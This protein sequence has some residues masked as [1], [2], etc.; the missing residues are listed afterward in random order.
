MFTLEVDASTQALD[1]ILEQSRPTKEG[2]IVACGGRSLRGA[3]L[4]YTVTELEMLS[5]VEALNKN[6]PFLIGRHFII[7]SDHLSLR[8]ISSLKDCSVGRLFQLSFQIQGFDFEL[9]YL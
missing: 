9:V 4:N 5:V 6:R 8:F 1:H 3:D 2:G 7:M